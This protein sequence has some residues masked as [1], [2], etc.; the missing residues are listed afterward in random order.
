MSL[1]PVKQHIHSSCSDTL[2]SLSLSLSIALSLHTHTY[3]PSQAYRH[4]A[5]FTIGFQS[6]RQIHYHCQTMHRH[7]PVSFVCCPHFVIESNHLF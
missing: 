4:D 5:I 7:V 2:L 6:Q 3:T 1:H